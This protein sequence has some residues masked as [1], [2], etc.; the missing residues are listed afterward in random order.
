[1]LHPITHTR[2]RLFLVV[3]TDM[4]KSN[5]HKAEHRKFHTSMRKKFFTWKVLEQYNR[6]PRE[7]V[8]SLSLEILGCF[9]VQPT[10]WNLI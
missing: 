4:I 2:A 9:P 8:W 6:L 1:M 7:V 3:P 5:R 10:L